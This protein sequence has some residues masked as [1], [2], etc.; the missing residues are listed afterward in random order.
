MD[1]VKVKKVVNI[2]VNVVLWLF[3]AFAA[4]MTVIA[5]SATSNADRIPSI[6]GKYLLTVQSNSM[7]PVFKQGDLIFGT[8]LTDEEKLQLNEDDV[9]TYFADLDGDGIKQELNTHRIVEVVKDDSGNVIAYKTQGDNREMSTVSETISV[10][11]I[12]SRWD[13][14]KLGGVGGLITFMQ[15]PT[16]FLC[17]IVLPIALLFFYQIFVFVRAVLQVKNSGKRQ[18][19]AADEE[20]IK[21]RAVEE[22]LRSQAAQ[23]DGEQ[24]SSAS[25]ETA[26]GAQEEKPD[27]DE[28]EADTEKPADNA[29]EGKPNGDKK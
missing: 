16:G 9:V 12:V 15:K 29:N 14:G 24:A 21:Q 18:I 2:V 28:D 10:S 22:Y 23:N 17:V 6:G 13:G 11:D 26:E 4:V 20:L 1:K 3:L 25:S 19:T 27:E 5:I 8:V 7:T